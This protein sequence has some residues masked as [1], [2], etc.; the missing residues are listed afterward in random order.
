MSSLASKA[1]NL[2]KPIEL[3]KGKP[4][5][6]ILVFWVPILLS[7]FFQQMYTLMDELIVGH[8]LAAPLVAGIDDTNSLVFLILQFAF[9]C[10]AGFS[11]VSSAKV[12][13]HDPEGVRRSFVTQL[14]LALLVSIALTAIAVPCVGPLLQ[15]LGLSPSSQ[16][17]TYASARIFITTIYAGLFTQVFYNLICAFLRSLGDS[18]TPFLFLVGSTALSV[19]LDFLFVAGIPQY[20]PDFGQPGAGGVFGAA[21]SVDIAQFAAAAGC[22]IYA[23]R[24]YAYIRP[25]R[26]DWRFDWGFAWEHLRLGLPLA[27]Q[28]SIL[29]IGLILLQNNVLSFDIFN[30][31]YY[32]DTGSFYTFRGISFAGFVEGGTRHFVDAQNAFGPSNK[33]EVSLETAQDSFG[34]AMLSYCSQN[35]GARNYPRIKKGLNQAF[36]IMGIISALLTAVSLLSTI[37]GA[38]LYLFLKPEYVTPAVKYYGTFYLYCVSPCY[39]ILGVLFIVRSSVQGLGKSL[40]PLLAGIGELIARTTVSLFLPLIINPNPLLGDPHYGWAFFSVGF[41]SPLAWVFA[42]MFPIGALV[43]YVYRGN[44][45]KKDE[46]RFGVRGRIL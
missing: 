37:N 15:V 12:G 44:L 38:Y 8:F 16:P 26:S 1:K 23:L 17:E 45:E 10:T 13:E 7:Y 6:V 42:S 27:L 21:L 40:F 34:A 18:L 39:G 31:N 3:T 36:V 41:A 9:G 43:Y 33:W 30:E 35:R 19:G 14:F 24:R 29:A 28:F 2:F 11:V 4:W 32:R 20:L 5:Q 25:Q 22:I 46:R